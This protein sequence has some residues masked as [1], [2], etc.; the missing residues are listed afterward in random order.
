[1]ER[2]RAVRRLLGLVLVMALTSACAQIERVISFDASD[3]PVSAGFVLSDPETAR[4]LS[5]EGYL[6]DDPEAAPPAGVPV[7]DDASWLSPAPVAGERV[8]LGWVQRYGGRLAALSAALVSEGRARGLTVTAQPPSPDVAQL[9][10]RGAANIDIAVQPLCRDYLAIRYVVRSLGIEVPALVPGCARPVPPPAPISPEA[11]AL[12]FPGGSTPLRT[13]TLGPFDAYT[14]TYSAGGQSPALLVD[15][16]TQALRTSGYAA[17]ALSA[18]PE[19]PR[20]SGALVGRRTGVVQVV[21]ACQGQVLVRYLLSKA[22]NRNAPTGPCAGRT[23]PLSTD[24]GGAVPTRLEIP[25]GRLVA[26]EAAADVQ[27]R[28]L[29]PTQSSVEAVV[30]AERSALAQDRTVFTDVP[31]P[32][33]AVSTAVDVDRGS[34]A[35]GAV[36]AQVTVRPLCSGTVGVVV[37]TAEP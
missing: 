9:T 37:V 16:L 33:G 15:G 4:N 21:A 34:R 23:K 13:G 6:S 30:L 22:P 20:A 25:P 31:S 28:T 17:T 10:Y 12:P 5:C 18:R 26:D 14:A 32:A 1:M 8:Y 19:A 29:V 2:T 3:Q 24:A 11:A 27:V 36:S 35:P 7:P